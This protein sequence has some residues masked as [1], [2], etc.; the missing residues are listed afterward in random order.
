[1]QHLVHCV[2]K[3]RCVITHMRQLCLH[4]GCGHS[5][6]THLACRMADCVTWEIIER[7]LKLLFTDNEP[8][9]LSLAFLLYHTNWTRV[10][11]LL[12]TCIFM[13]R[14]PPFQIVLSYVWIQQHVVRDINNKF[15]IWLQ[16]FTDT[17]F[18]WRSYLLTC[19]LL[20]G[21]LRFIVS[22]KLW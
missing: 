15:N 4:R 2:S 12:L 14:T 18:T 5:L 1:M 10:E 3:D 16:F 11:V 19:R 9:N 22:Y 13:F 21:I 6:K 7:D 17:I 20:N 8:C